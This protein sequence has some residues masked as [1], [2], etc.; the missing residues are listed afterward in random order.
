MIELL[1]VIG[2][3]GIL[4]AG[5]L[6]TIDPLEQFRKGADNNRKTAS[7]E[8]VN[9]IARYYATKGVMPW[10]ANG[11]NCNAGANPAQVKVSAAAFGDCL[12]ALT[13]Q[14]ELKDTFKGSQ[15]LSDLYV[16]GTATTLNVCYDPQSKAES[17]RA[18]T[19]YDIAGVANAAC[20]AAAVACYWCAK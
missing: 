15:V 19:Q 11:D 20:P 13:N 9:A 18:E 2:V 16:N 10:A 6:A 17:L 4:A 5:L 12:T 3:L 14:G 8:L 1:V 7:V